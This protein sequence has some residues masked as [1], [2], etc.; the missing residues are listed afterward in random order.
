MSDTQNIA[1]PITGLFPNEHSEGEFDV[2]E[3]YGELLIPIISDGPRGVEHFNLELGAR[4]SD[5]SMEQMPNLET[6]KALMD[7]AVSPRYR[8]RGGFNRAF[9][10]PNLGEL[11]IRRTQVFAAGGAT[12]DWCSQNLS[13]PGSFSATPP[14]G[15]NGTP[16]AQTLQTTNMCRSLMGSDGAFLYY[17]NRPITEQ[18]DA[19]SG[20]GIPISFGNPRPCARSRP[21][22]GR[23]VSRW[24]SSRTGR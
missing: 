20:V 16:T 23:S 15:R 3:I 1:D 14:D 10:A 17:D 19:M 18:P 22:R 9:R 8:I 7:W 21:T 4:V 13:N 12:R 6:Y 11:Y 5:W 2:S 24:T